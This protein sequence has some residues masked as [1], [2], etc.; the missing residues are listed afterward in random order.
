[1][2][3]IVI[4]IM[5]FIMVLLFVLVWMNHYYTKQE[6]EILREE[7][8]ELKELVENNRLKNMAYTQ[9]RIMEN[10]LHNEKIFDLITTEINLLHTNKLSREDIS[11]TIEKLVKL[12]T[13]EHD[14]R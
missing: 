8:D 10:D 11:L 2:R 5:M 9:K 7:N 3:D 14:E 12:Y 13:E 4:Y 1:M 6:F